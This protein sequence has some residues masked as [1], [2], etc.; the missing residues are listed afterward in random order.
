[1]IFYYLIDSSSILTLVLILSFR[2][3][4][5]V[6]KIVLDLFTYKQMLCIIR[7]KEE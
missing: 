6:L 2:H 7:G 5:T 1:M 4:L 3:L